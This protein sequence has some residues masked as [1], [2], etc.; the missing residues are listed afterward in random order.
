NMGMFGSYTLRYNATD[1]SGN[2]NMT[3]RMVN[4]NDTIPPV[5]KVKGPIVLAPPD[6]KY[7]TFTI[8]DFVKSVTDSCTTGIGI[9]DVVITKVSS[10]E[11]E[12][13][14]G[15]GKTL[16]DIVIGSDRRSTKL[17]VERSG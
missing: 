1:P 3:S 9:A 14:I 15:D 5:I 2:T 4:V 11:P 13:G 6:H 10:D 7:D 17:R 16:M 12:D 8:A